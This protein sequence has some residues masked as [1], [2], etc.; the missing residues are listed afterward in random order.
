M[1]VSLPGDTSPAAAL[2]LRGVIRMM[3]DLGYATLTELTLANGRRA[4]IAALGPAGEFAI[5]E[6][7]S[8]LADYRADR[9]WRDYRAFCDR[10]FFAVDEAFPRDC[11]PGDA[12]LIVA[13]RFGGAIL[14][15]A[16]THR[17]APARRKALTLRFARLSAQRL[18]GEVLM[19]MDAVARRA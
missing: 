16:E 10:F 8:C 3:A 17:L 4:D 1:P 7:K 6:V 12:G 5:I 19:H 15:D 11:L 2:I 13:D 9:K 14:R 18:H